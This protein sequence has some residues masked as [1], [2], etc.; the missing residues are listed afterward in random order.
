[1]TY[2]KNVFSRYSGG[3]DEI[4]KTINKKDVL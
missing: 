4:R 1:L 3:K 2:L